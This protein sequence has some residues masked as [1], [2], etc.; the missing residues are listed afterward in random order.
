[1][2]EGHG[3]GRRFLIAFG[4]GRYVNLGDD[5]QLPRVNDDIAEV[6]RLFQELGYTH[7]LP[8]LGEYASAAQIREKL[9]HWSADARLTDDDVVVV[10]F[11]G[12]G[13][14]QDRDRHYLLCWD[15]R[16]DD[17]AATA[18]A[19]E[20]LARILCRG[21]LR[22][23]LLILDTCAGGAGGA[24][25]AGI[26]LRTIAYRQS[27]NAVSTGLW[28]LA[29]ARRKDVADDGA[30]VAAF[31]AGVRTAAERT[32]QR[33]RYL[34]L[35]ELVR[36]INERFERDGRGQRAELASGLV[37]G[38][39]PFFPNPGFR[40]D[41]PPAG[42]DLELQRRVSGGDLSEHFGPR[43]RG[44]E[45]ESEQGLYFS[46]REQ[47]LSELVAW[48]TAPTGDGRGRAVT[49]SPGCGKSAVLGRIVA[50]SDKSYRSRFDLSEVDPATVVPE[51]CVTAAVHARH[52]RLEQVVERI[53]A[54]L[55]TR[56][57]G[58][59]ALLQ[60][61]TRRGRQG[62]PLVIVVDA[63]D[64]AGS[65]TAADSGGHGEPRRIARE[66]LRPMAEIPGVR[67]LVGTRRELISS[68]G[69]FTV[70]DLDQP[71]YRA[72]EDDV[73]GY[74]T[75]VLMAADEPETKTPY[76][77]RPELAATVARAVAERA[78][79]VYLYARTTARTL[80]KDSAP[81][82][83]SRP[84]WADKLPSEVGEAF[85]DYL[86]RFGPDEQRIRRMLL[87]LAFSE[88]RGLPR[89][90]VWTALATALSGTLCTD[91]DVSWTLDHASAYIAEVTD[92]DKRS[93]YRLY[94]KALAEHLR[95]TCCRPQVE[96][97]QIIVDALISITPRSASRPG[98]DWFAAPPYVRHHLATHA[99]EAGR[100]AALVRDPGFLLASEQL[101]LL[102][103]LP[104]LSGDAEQRV[105]SAYEQVA[106]RLT[107]EHPL[108][109]RAAEL[110]L[111]AR[112]CGA[113]ELAEAIDGL[114]IT[115]PCAT[116]WAWWAKRGTH[117]VLSGHTASITCVAAGDLDGRPIV[118]TGSEDKTARIWDLTT[119]RQIGAALETTVEVSAVAVGDLEDYTVALTGGID[120][121]VRIWDISTGQQYG[122]PL[123]GHTNGVSAIA[124]RRFGDRFVAVTASS[125]G[126]ARIWDLKTRTQIGPPMAEHRSTVNAAALGELD[127]RPIALT[128][129]N[130]NRAYIWDL[131]ELLDGTG[132]RITVKPLIGHSA[133]V[134]AVAV[135]RLDGRPVGLVGDAAGM[136]GLWDLRER[137][138]I[139]EPVLADMGAIQQTVT[140]VAVG[141][142]GGRLTV[143]TS[144]YNDARQ[145]DLNGLRQIGHPLRGHS[146]YLTAAALA[147]NGDRPLAITAGTDGTARIWDLVTEQPPAGHVNHVRAVAYA[148]IDGRPLAITGGND[149][150]ARI[151]DLRTRQEIGRPLE[152]HSEAVLTVALA[153]VNGRPLAATGGSDTTIR[154]WDPLHG[155]PYRRPLKGHTNA[156]RC[157][158][159]T[160]LG[161]EAVV[162]SGSDDGTIRVW[163]VE[164]GEPVCAPLAGHIGAINRLA[165][166]RSGTGIEIAATTAF[167]HAYT[168]RVS[169]GRVPSA[170]AA[171]IDLGKDNS[172]DKT[173]GVG[174]H[175]A[176]PVVFYTRTDNSVH[177][178]DIETDQAIG[179]P[180]VGHTD[181][182]WSAALG[183]I[184]S[185]PCLITVGGDTTRIW[186]LDTGD[187]IGEL[188]GDGERR[189]VSSSIAFGRIDGTPIGITAF[190]EKVRVWNLATQMPIDEPLCGSSNEVIFVAL[191]TGDEEV[192]ITGTGDG[193]L[194]FHCP[195]DGNQVRPHLITPLS[196]DCGL[197]ISQRSGGPIGVVGGWRRT[198]IWDLG[199][200]R[201]LGIF[202][203]STVWTTCVHAYLL[204]DRW[205][206]A[207]GC[208]N[209]I[210]IWDLMTQARVRG[211]LLGH[212]ATVRDVWLGRAR[213]EDVAV[214]ASDDGTVRVWD[215]QDGRG[216]LAPLTCSGYGANT[217]EIARLD[218][219]EIVLS[220]WDD[221]RVRAWDIWTGSAVNLALEPFR[222]GV[223]L[224]RMTALQRE[225][226]LVAAD[227]EGLLRAWRLRTAELIAE[228]DIGSTINDLAATGDGDLYLGTD[229][230]TVALRLSAP[231]ESRE[232][233]A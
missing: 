94:H 56:V 58:T 183:H 78:A 107:A 132:D 125:D 193:T 13:M 97:Q 57:D 82:D 20:D 100:L 93:V 76:R 90:D 120:G 96:V 124:V 98:R 88:G 14:V 232:V 117:R 202:A 140:S 43:S 69:S 153:R 138:Q 215:L 122:P 223:K 17:P 166:R 209:E 197:V 41:L 149:C 32:G 27:G 194:R 1:M 128:G 68:L 80:R 47:V 66:L 83:T 141:E 60:E 65:D 23:L 195:R 169:T 156:V 152:G 206:A 227:F 35:T 28:F 8:G 228:V 179:K 210:H 212:T 155:V 121:V 214:S 6:T 220:G 196:L 173:V 188:L 159:L 137:Q 73:A 16:E 103:A 15:S 174:F 72:S 108:S 21:E 165:V 133:A 163:A 2:G 25:A 118:V 207:S 222:R 139:G 177:I 175:A 144:G 158:A 218:E 36:A 135:G 151:W 79:G 75:K 22:H 4:T 45:F 161:D 26:A 111:S 113:D 198:E 208:E 182:V 54:A 200:R 146:G 109:R 33:Q 46:G 221:G 63:L 59:A 50:L 110:Q 127:G 61:L 114:G 150:T 187:Q 224:L 143:L 7:V 167:G 112:R 99:A 74:V 230:G 231:N 129:G 226:V 178:C 101:A 170:P 48:V 168:W 42:T 192:A 18:L 181:T 130:D 123:T 205:I 77:E 154:L 70:L 31:R 84:G 30:F 185:R 92:D 51:G 217:V 186:D 9:S 147:G 126:T 12:H 211:P 34:D 190:G 229:M 62:P 86:A 3:V 10:Y 172:T 87:P 203:S 105:R 11:A 67:L 162:V 134:T 64:E 5:D 85:D 191:A 37:T 176:R 184:D 160:V 104:S 204:G 102:S 39:A 38:L 189:G 213:G 142:F 24:D 216:L 131:R 40:E 233:P 201:R 115:L 91:E 164:S 171:H 81:I 52:K 157:L 148:D 19:T 199:A 55:G 29:S 71:K 225:P 119:Q 106:H 136:L 116:R 89:S 49:G 219:Q 145:W 53:A 180:L 44:V 95:R